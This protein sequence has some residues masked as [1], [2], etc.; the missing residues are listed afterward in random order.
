MC[1]QTEGRAQLPLLLPRILTER[2]TLL[3]V[4]G[5]DGT[6]ATVV[7]HLAHTDTVVAEGDGRMVWVSA[8][9]GR[10]VSIPAALRSTI[11]ACL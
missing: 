9:S 3:V 1:K 10:P 5:G 6:V 4:G 8:E 7:D 2:P 11:E